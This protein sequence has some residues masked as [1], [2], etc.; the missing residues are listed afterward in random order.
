MTIWTGVL[1]KLLLRLRGKKD[2]FC[3]DSDFPL[4][5][6]NA[7]LDKK[8]RKKSYKSHYVSEFHFSQNREKIPCSKDFIN[9]LET[10]KKCREVS[11]EAVKPWALESDWMGFCVQAPPFSS[12]VTSWRCLPSLSPHFPLPE[13]FTKAVAETCWVQ[14]Q[15]QCWGCGLTVPQ[16][17]QG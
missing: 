7:S 13:L 15:P 11:E 4:I 14:T 16:G 5:P 2:H 17:T 1:L 12:C 8:E 9:S 6:D 10:Q 3:Y